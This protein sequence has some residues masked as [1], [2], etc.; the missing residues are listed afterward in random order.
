MTHQILR[1]VRSTKAIEKHREPVGA[2]RH[3]VG[4]AELR[5]FQEPIAYFSET[6]QLF[7]KSR[8]YALVRSQAR[9]CSARADRLL[10]CLPACLLT[11]F[12]TSPEGNRNV[13]SRRQLL[14]PLCRAGASS[15]LVRLNISLLD[16]V[17][18]VANFVAPVP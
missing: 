7:A 16:V 6:P 15:V 1:A 2:S 4:G 13:Q 18:P 14:L 9:F 8:G 12:C 5:K 10:A 3:L 11:S 17:S